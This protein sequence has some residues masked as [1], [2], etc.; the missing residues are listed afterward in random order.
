MTNRG[1]NI[2]MENNTGYKI[3]YPNDDKPLSVVKSPKTPNVSVKSNVNVVKSPETPNVFVQ[4]R[5][6]VVNPYAQVQQSRIPVNKAVNNQSV[7]VVKPPVPVAPKNFNATHY[8]PMDPLQTKPNPD[9]IGAFNRLVEFGDVA[10]GQWNIPKDTFIK[11]PELSDVKTPYGMGVFRVNDRKNERYNLPNSPSFD[12][13][14]PVGTPNREALQRRIGNRDMTFEPAQNNV[15][16]VESPETPE[17]KAVARSKY[18]L[19]RPEDFNPS[20]FDDSNLFDKLTMKLLDKPVKWLEKGWEAEK[21]WDEMDTGDKI[22]A[23]LRELPSTAFRESLFAGSG[24]LGTVEGLFGAAEWLG[25]D[26]AKTPGDK[27]KEWRDVSTPKEATFVDNLFS[28]IGSMAT[29]YIPGV[30][31]M[32]GVQLLSTFSPKLAMLVG[33]S[34]MTL[35]ESATEAGDTY[36]ESTAKGD[37]K[38]LAKSKSDFVFYSNVLLLGITNK[39]GMFNDAIKNT[40]IKMLVS[41]PL[42]GIQEFG[43]SVLSNT[44]NEKPWSE[45]AVQSGII[46]TILG[47]FGGGAIDTK[48]PVPTELQEKLKEEIKK[49]TDKASEGVKEY[50]KNPKIGASIE[51]VSGRTLEEKFLEVK[52]AQEQLFTE[53]KQGESTK[54]D[55]SNVEVPTQYEESLFATG[56]ETPVD[57]IEQ[58]TK[59]LPPDILSTIEKPE[60]VFEMAIRTPNDK[61]V[62]FIDKILRTPW[63]VMRRFG[64]Q[65]QFRALIQA[66]EN[67][68][69]EMPQNMNI[70][71]EWSEILPKENTTRVFDSLDGKNVK[72]NGNIE[73]GIAKEIRGWM[74][75]WAVR[76]KVPKGQRISE[77]I[78]HIFEM[79]DKGDVPEIISAMIADK[80]AKSVYNPFQLPRKGAEGYKRD[81]W[82]ALEAYTKR[83]TRKAN[84]DPALEEFNKATASLTEPS[85][86]KYIERRISTLNMR[87]TEWEQA[88]DNTIKKVFPKTG[89]RPTLRATSTVRKTISRSKIGG[90]MTS[91]A[92][93]LTQGVNTLAELGEKYTVIGYM[94]LVKF[95][96]KELKENSVLRDSFYKDTKYN[97]LKR[98]SEN[99]DKVL[100]FN[101]NF[102]ELINRGA[103]YYGAK[104]KY[105]DGKITPKEYE[106]CFGEEMYKKVE[107][108][109]AAVFEPTMEEAIQ[110]GKFISEKTQFLFGP[111]ETQGILSS[112]ISKTALQFQTFSLKQAEFTVNMLTDKDYKKLAR[113]LFY[114]TMI[115]SYIGRAFGMK[116]DDSIK[117]WRWGKPPI[118][119]FLWDDLWRQ[120]IVGKDK[121]GNVLSNKEKAKVLGNSFLTNVIPAGAQIKKS[122]EGFNAVN[123]GKSTT[124]SGNFQYKIDKTLGNY[125]RGTL[126][127][128]YN[129]PQAQDYYKEQEDKKKAA[130]KRRD[131]TTNSSGGY[132]ISY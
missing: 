67:Y 112:P 16:V 108:S 59:G 51:D 90:S 28:G 123:E 113:Y 79:D 81:L 7:N 105:L 33:G 13:A 27:V 9:G 55:E 2:V 87:P 122:V 116:W 102:S 21:G 96:Y 18:N 69:L 60:K 31:A 132:N 103:A 75:Q 73:I 111:L 82:A 86:L 15:N 70:I 25:I 66:Y 57:T 84:L 1:Y 68:V 109:G 121:Y 99:T 3:V 83:A 65:K 85:Q 64:V 19:Q 72:L 100:F 106:L 101:M 17:V 43:Q 29:F 11:V 46:G 107:P 126:W 44:A 14:L 40:L 62:G 88:F 80:Q 131:G 92:K 8:D 5:P 36:R 63:R 41:A 10:T 32:K 77:Y 117:F 124:K 127:G 49:F 48:S 12:I 104:Q 118:L 89:P 91:L 30:G 39:F 97:A 35:L 54:Q 20:Q 95:G 120:V 50:I 125:I 56:E 110:Y 47:L 23:T 34:V 71:R 45:G 58:I 37:D 26:A 129:L 53:T 128:K 93:N 76:L 52:P 114:S 4:P 119:Q 94:D 115:F 78:P 74:D 22:K 38:S 6:G 61:K 130:A 98:F 42:E 24:V